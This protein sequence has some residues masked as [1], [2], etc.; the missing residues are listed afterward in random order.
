MG[1][2]VNRENALSNLYLKDSDFQC[3]NDG[4]MS[5]FELMDCVSQVVG[6]YLH[7][8][9]LDR[10]LWRVYLSDSASRQ[11]L[12]TAGIQFQNFNFCSVL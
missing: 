5:D 11:K 3:S 9:Q 8:L 7:C 6:N 10:N 2:P 1:S 4:K 12:L